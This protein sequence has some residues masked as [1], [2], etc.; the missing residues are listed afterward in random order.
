LKLELIPL[1]ARGSMKQADAAKTLNL[2]DRQVRRLVRRYDEGGEAALLHKARGKPSNHQLAPEHRSKVI[3]LIRANFMDSGPRLISEELQLMND[4]DVHPETIRR[5]MIEEKL[6]SPNDPSKVLH[7]QSRE[8]RACRGELVQMDTS[9]HEWLGEGLGEQYML[10]MIDDASNRVYPRLYDADTTRNNMDHIH[11]YL[12]LYGRPLALYVDHSSIFIHNFPNGVTRTPDRAKSDE[13]NTQVQR[14]AEQ[15]GINIIYARSPQAKGRIER[16]F[17]T[18]QTKVIKMLAHRGIHTIDEANAFLTGEF[19]SFW[20]ARYTVKPTLAIDMH[21]SIEGYDL[22][23]ILCEHEERVVTNDYT[24][25]WEGWR[26]QIDPRDVIS[27]MRRGKVIIEIRTNGSIK[28]NYKGVYI[29]FQR[30][31]KV[32]R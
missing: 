32:N 11:G 6:W 28:V 1:V 27:N 20:E 14:A 7:R 31:K 2:T 29:N 17:G 16:F 24:F 26:Y 19:F 8:R 12:G 3:S 23:A 30:I 25:Q 15:L 22:D 10:A 9:V 13:V 21:R 5:W 18:A 4:M